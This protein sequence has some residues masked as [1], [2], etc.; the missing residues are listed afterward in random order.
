MSQRANKFEVYLSSGMARGQPWHF[1]SFRTP[2]RYTDIILMYA[3]SRFS[4]PIVLPT[5]RAQNMGHPYLRHS[6]IVYV[7]SSN[8]TYRWNVYVT[9]T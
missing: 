2:T 3:L 5:D 8:F 9:T 6:G 7:S 4:C 1:V